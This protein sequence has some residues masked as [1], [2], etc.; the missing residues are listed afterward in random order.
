MR[1]FTF[2]LVLTATLI[3]VPSSG[4]AQEPPALGID[5]F[6]DPERP[7][8]VPVV[9]Q[10][11]FG[12][13]LTTTAPAQNVRVH[14]EGAGLTVEDDT[15]TIPALD[16]DEWEI[17]DFLVSADTPGFHSLTVT[18]SADDAEPVTAS[19]PH[20]WAPGGPP[21]SATGSLAGRAYGW[22]GTVSGVTG[23]SSSRVTNMV[24]FV[25]S[26]YA[27]VG[28]PPRG[29]PRCPTRGCV[30]Y[31][32]D[33]STGF[34][35]VGDRRIGQVLG[36]RLYLEGFASGDVWDYPDFVIGEVLD[37]PVGMPKH[38]K[39]SGTW[40]YRS[41]DYPDGLTYQRLT[42]SRSGTFRLAFEWDGGP[43]RR[44]RGE[45]R[46]GR[47]GHLVLR[48]RSSTNALHGTLLVRENLFGIQKP[49]TLGV[50][51]ILELHRRNGTVVDGNPLRPA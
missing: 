21:L 12:L 2:L 17:T 10:E 36:P 4:A 31:Y 18:V 7:L 22:S 45:Y 48:G 44:L 5:F 6:D 20:L 47:R 30:R 9:G 8:F 13:R 24:T 16:P 37:R 42:L 26:R 19:L 50:W 40:S 29:V 38:Q 32:Y 34:V 33:V 15:K 51:L 41:R 43:R 39:Y 28:L 3:G 49:G 35:Q 27:Y 23:E 14:A 11:G 25:D 46:L 1:L